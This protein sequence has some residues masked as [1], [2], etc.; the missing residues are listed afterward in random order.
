MKPQVAV[1]KSLR[2]TFLN[3]TTFRKLE[4][5]FSNQQVL[6]ACAGV[7]LLRTGRRPQ[8]ELF[9]PPHR[10]DEVNLPSVRAL[11]RAICWRGTPGFFNFGFSAPVISY[12]QNSNSVA[13]KTTAMFHTPP[14]AKLQLEPSAYLYGAALQ[15]GSNQISGGVDCWRQNFHLNQTQQPFQ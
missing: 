5:H 9:C 4:M 1:K 11:G 2:D 14:H 12:Q 6:M 8:F 13:A 10:S 3:F 7:T 15:I